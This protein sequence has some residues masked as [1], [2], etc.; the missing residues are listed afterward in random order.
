MLE[1][2]RYYLIKKKLFKKRFFRIISNNSQTL[3]IKLYNLFKKRVKLEIKK[4]K[5]KVCFFSNKKSKQIKGGS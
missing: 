2:T 3:K 4:Q 1:L 5:L